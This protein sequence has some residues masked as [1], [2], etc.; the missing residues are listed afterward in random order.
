MD[1]IEYDVCDVTEIWQL[2]IPRFV[3]IAKRRI[4]KIMSDIVDLVV[5]LLVSSF[6][7]ASYIP[8]HVQ[9]LSQRSATGLSLWT[10]LI[11]TVS[12]VALTISSVLAGW[13]SIE[14]ATMQHAHSKKFATTQT[15]LEVAN[16]GMPMLQSLLM[17]CVGTPSYVVYFFRFGSSPNGV[18]LGTH[19]T[20]ATGHDRGEASGGRE[21]TLIPI[22]ESRQRAELISAVLTWASII[23]TTAASAWALVKFGSQS[24]VVTFLVKLWGAIATFTN[25][26]QWIPQIDTTWKAKHEGVLSISSLIFSVLGDLL[27]AFFWIGGNGESIWVYMTLAADASMQIIL[28]GIILLFQRQ[29]RL[30]SVIDGEHENRP[31]TPLLFATH[32]RCVHLD[33]EQT[34]EGDMDQSSLGMVRAAYLDPPEA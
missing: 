13:H 15:V 10:V 16:L 2:E 9:C 22:H 17:V 26:V 12:G 32:K 11:S 3:W 31:S 4:H 23:A 1:M 33:I 8:Q 30:Q 14:I 28:I 34:A 19:A 5:G 29:R 27:L 7:V 18:D 21:V 24:A 25:L 20:H 6:V